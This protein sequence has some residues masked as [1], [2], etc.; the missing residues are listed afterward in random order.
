[1]LKGRKSDLPCTTIYSKEA[2]FMVHVS[3]IIITNASKV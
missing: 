1:M 2:N 3:I